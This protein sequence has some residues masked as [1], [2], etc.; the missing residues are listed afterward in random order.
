MGVKGIHERRH[1]A[2]RAK[3]RA[4]R[5][6]GR[7]SDGEFLRNL[8]KKERG[9]ILGIH[10]K[11]RTACSCDMCRQEPWETGSKSGLRAVAKA[12]YQEEE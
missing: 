11:M 5:E 3:A 12:E 7:W 1:Q 2:K 6:V 9:R 4:E 8:S 10:S